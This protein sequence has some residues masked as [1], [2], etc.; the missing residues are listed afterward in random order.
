MH[1]LLVQDM[2]YPEC[3]QPHP[4]SK[5]KQDT[6]K[7]P[8]WKKLNGW[9]QRPWPGKELFLFYFV[10]GRNAGLAVL[11]LASHPTDFGANGISKVIQGSVVQ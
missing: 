8:G 9:N 4:I 6:A 3:K 11:S 7:L 1:F 10:A 5:P 2:F